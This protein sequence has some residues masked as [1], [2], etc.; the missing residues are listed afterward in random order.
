MKQNA[1]KNHKKNGFGR[2]AHEVA[3]AQD[4]LQEDAEIAEEDKAQGVSPRSLRSPVIFRAGR[5]IRGCSLPSIFN[6]R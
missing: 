3:D 2:F 6:H 4:S 5:R 1:V